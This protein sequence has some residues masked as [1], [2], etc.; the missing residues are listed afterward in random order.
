MGFSYLCLGET[1]E[2]SN[3]LKAKRN[4]MMF[5]M[6]GRVALHSFKLEGSSASISFVSNYVFSI[7]RSFYTYQEISFWKCLGTCE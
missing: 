3:A 4:K 5:S 2:K 7:I 1:K 6:L